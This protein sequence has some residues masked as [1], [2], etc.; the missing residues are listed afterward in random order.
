MLTPVLVL[1][2]IYVACTVALIWAAVA[3]TR[4]IV[5]QRRSTRSRVEPH[6]E[7]V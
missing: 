5:Q 6:D 7:S 1:Y 2:G 4:H 3:V